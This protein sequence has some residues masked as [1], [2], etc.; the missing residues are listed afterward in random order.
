MINLIKPKGQSTL[1]YVI[2]LTAL[3]V[4]FIVG[5][6]AVRNALIG[7]DEESGLIGQAADTIPNW[8]SQLPGADQ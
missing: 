2:I 5:T 4:A 6:T 8:T 3:A 7:E 1:E